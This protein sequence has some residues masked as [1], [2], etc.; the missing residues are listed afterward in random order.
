MDSVSVG[1]NL[2]VRCGRIQ[3]AANIAR[4]SEQAFGL[5]PQSVETLQSFGLVGQLL[6]D[7]AD[8]STDVGKQ[9]VK[10]LQDKKQVCNRSNRLGEAAEVSVSTG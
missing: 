3:D 5:P 1:S 9:I 8:V 2:R 4:I 6:A 7:A 10:T